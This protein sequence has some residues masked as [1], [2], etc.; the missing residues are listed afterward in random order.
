M[1]DFAT[2][3]A[4]ILSS[5]LVAEVRLRRKLSVEA[6]QEV[7]EWYDQTA[8]YAAQIRRLWQRQWDLDQSRANFGELASNINLLESEMSR[9]ASEGEQL[10]VD[11]GVVEALDDVTDSC[12]DVSDHSQYINDTEEINEYREDMLDAVSEL[13]ETLENCR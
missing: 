8:A 5:V 11:Q 3:L 4:S 7:V 9:H 6:S 12:R 2:V 13:E 1:V 10:D